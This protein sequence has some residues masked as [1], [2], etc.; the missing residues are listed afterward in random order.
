[1]KYPDYTLATAKKLLALVNQSTEAV[2]ISNQ[3]IKQ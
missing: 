3:N 1:V 2:L